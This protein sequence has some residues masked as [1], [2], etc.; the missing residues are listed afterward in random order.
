MTLIELLNFLGLLMLIG[1]NVW[2]G[3]LLGLQVGLA[4]T[5]ILVGITFLSQK[6]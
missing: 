5:T 3:L 2:I 1:G 6:T 4:I